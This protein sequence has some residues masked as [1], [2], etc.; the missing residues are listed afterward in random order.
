MTQSDTEKHREMKRD[1]VKQRDTQ[2]DTEIER[3]R[4]IV[5]NGSLVTLKG[6]DVKLTEV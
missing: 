4:D 3:E 2:R 5:C 6:M 1:R